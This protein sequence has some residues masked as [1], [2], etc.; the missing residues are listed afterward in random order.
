MQSNISIYIWE[1]SFSQTS[2]VRIFFTN[3][4][5]S[6]FKLNHYISFHPSRTFSLIRFSF[7]LLN[8]VCRISLI[9]STTFA[10]SLSPNAMHRMCFPS[11]IMSFNNY[12]CQFFFSLLFAVFDI[13]RFFQAKTN[14]RCS[15]AYCAKRSLI[16]K[17]TQH[18]ESSTINDGIRCMTPF[19]LIS[20]SIWQKKVQK[21]TWRTKRYAKKKKNGEFHSLTLAFHT[22]H[23]GKVA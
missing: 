13:F 15:F 17:I 21:K 12:I 9:P 11:L 16:S 1:I 14:A 18:Q 22:L 7:L 8:G 2:S 3:Q 20:Y 23:I 10:T 4:S 5:I 6:L 19:F